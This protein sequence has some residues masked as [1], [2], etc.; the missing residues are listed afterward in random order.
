M[1]RIVRLK[2]AQLRA[3]LRLTTADGFYLSSE[4]LPS[5]ARTVACVIQR[6]H[7]EAA[8]LLALWRNFDLAR[9][10]AFC[11][12]ITGAN[13][14]DRYACLKNNKV[15]SVP[16]VSRFHCTA[17]ILMSLQYWQRGEL[18]SLGR[19][20]LVGHF[21]NL[22]AVSHVHQISRWGT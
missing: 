8:A 20:V 9:F 13:I 6:A 14:Q 11:L 12:S 22:R 4:R 15:G 17:A 19:R 10:D 5:S 18:K 7:I 21:S 3:A 16:R 2:V 1:D